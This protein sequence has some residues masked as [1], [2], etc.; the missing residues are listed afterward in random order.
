M[1]DFFK[2]K[3]GQRVQVGDEQDMLHNIGIN[4]QRDNR[5][6]RRIL[7]DSVPACFTPEMS[8]L[9]GK[10]GVVTDVRQY[11]GDMRSRYL[12]NNYNVGSIQSVEINFD[13]RSLN[14]MAQNYKLTTPM[15]REPRITF[16]QYKDN[17]GFIKNLGRSSRWG[18]SYNSEK[19]INDGM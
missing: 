1:K 9:L 19:D 17:K 7:N 12:K 18:E 13:D 6:S 10:T 14:H 5:S 3:V 16:N 2:L 15:F 11:N 4:V 8:F